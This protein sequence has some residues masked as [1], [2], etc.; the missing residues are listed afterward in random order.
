MTIL[1][2]WVGTPMAAALGFAVLHSLWQGAILAAV[3]AAALLALRSPRARY[4]AACLAMLI[5][6]A[7]FGTTF[8]R[9]LP[10]RISAHAAHAPAF[11]AWNI[12]TVT[13]GP[14]SAHPG[15][16]VAVPWLAPFWI[17]GV[18]LFYLAQV[19]G[20]I[21][22]SRMRRRGVCCASQHWQ[23]E[24]ARLSE[25]LGLARPVLLLE[26]SLAEVPM[27]LGH[28]RPYLLMPVGLLAGLAPAQIE[29]ILLHEVAHIRRCDYLVNLCQR[30][31]EGLLFYHP[32]VWW[33]SRVIRAEREHCCD[34]VA[35]AASGDARVYAAALTALEENRWSG[36]EPAVAATGGSLVK[37]IRRLLH[38]QGPHSAW[39]SVIAA[40]ILIATA[41]MAFAAW[42][43]QPASA[44]TPQAAAADSPY[45]R[46]LNQDVVYIIADEERAAFEKLTTDAE[47]NEFIAQFWKRRDPKP[48]TPQ[49]E[50]KEEHYR[51]IAYA[52]DR[53]RTRSGRPGWQT[54]RGHMYIVYGPPD[55]LESHPGGAGSR[56]PYEIWLYHHV[57]GV[58]NNVT[59]TFI[60]RMA[61][62]DYRLA[63]GTGN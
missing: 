20:W 17:A 13:D 42:Q 21:S 62:G 6:L 1:Q 39:T 40:T 44:A 28:I 33:I 31:V 16:A 10:E 61:T 12:P 49:N 45:F 52:N 41:A 8:T 54:D 23:N 34:D 30:L 3:L 46:W 51:R 9:L 19:A 58:G 43:A 53:F 15:L 14:G 25:R 55:E 18:W 24:I 2:A 59:I 29:A 11:P 48:D 57:Q 4:A 22:L 47:R 5:I 38:P 27:V 56:Y 60:D 63:P 26:S 32:A 7:G 50:F 37:R 36:R 35:V